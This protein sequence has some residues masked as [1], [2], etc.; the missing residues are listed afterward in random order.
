MNPSN[1]DGGTVA[2]SPLLPSVSGFT[3]RGLND[4]IETHSLRI[5]G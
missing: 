4:R 2:P 1:G 5:R 3:E